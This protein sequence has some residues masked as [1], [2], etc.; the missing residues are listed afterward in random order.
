MRQRRAAAAVLLCC[1][2]VQ[3]VAA[4]MGQALCG[5]QQAQC[6]KNTY[7][8][9]NRKEVLQGASS[10]FAALVIGSQQAQA[11]GFGGGNDVAGSVLLLMQHASAR[12]MLTLL[13][14][15]LADCFTAMK[16]RFGD[17]LRRAA[18]LLDELQQDIFAEDWDLIASY[19][20]AFRALVPVFT[21][22][23]DAAF[24]GDDPVDKNSR[25]AL[26]YEVGR[27]FGAVER[28]KRAADARNTVET[29][30]AFSSMSVALDRYL[31]AGDLYE[32]YD[33]VTSTEKFYKGVDQSTLVFIPPARDPPKIRDSIM[34]VTGPDKGR[35]GRMIGQEIVASRGGATSKKA[36]IKLN[37]TL[38]G[39]REIKVVPYEMVAKTFQQG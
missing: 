32:A 23:T 21:K 8:S 34:L 27:F 37:N 14:F 29:E 1:I 3:H 39:I 36:V 24:P 7:M 20:N 9:L 2:T 13:L 4:F 31:K 22:Y 18:K 12:T 6:R 17:K 30:S 25:V 28:L 5:C 26:R 15:A 11:V 19:P 38:G 35:T 33:P 16:S 10:A